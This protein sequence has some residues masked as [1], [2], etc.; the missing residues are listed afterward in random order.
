[1]PHGNRARAA[2]SDPYRRR[3]HGGTTMRR[4]V[5]ILAVVACGPKQTSTPVGNSG[6]GSADSTGPV[7]VKDKR[8][9][10]ERRRDAACD[11]LGPRITK[12]AVEDAK[13]DLAAGKVK[14]AQFDQDTAPGVQQKNT[15][16]FI[17]KCKA[18]QYSS[19]QVRVLEVC[20]KQESECEPLLSC[21]EN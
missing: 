1:H 19:R 8:T 15:D 3:R 7:P 10:I 20:Q 18:G 9:E 17:K 6:S 13:K 5:L 11:T 16:E 2:V 21:L 14:K 12:W 4:L